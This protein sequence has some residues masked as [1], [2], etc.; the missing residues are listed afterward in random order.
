MTT[1]GGNIHELNAMRSEER[2][3]QS[4]IDQSVNPIINAII[5]EHYPVKVADHDHEHNFPSY[6]YMLIILRKR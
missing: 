5:N 4:E 2:G 6:V 3:K 1:A